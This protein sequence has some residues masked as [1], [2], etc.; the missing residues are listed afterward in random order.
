MF[1]QLLVWLMRAFLDQAAH[2]FDLQGQMM[3]HTRTN[4]MPNLAFWQVSLRHLDASKTLLQAFSPILSEIK[5]L[6]MTRKWCIWHFTLLRFTQAIHYSLPFTFIFC[7]QR[8]YYARPLISFFF[9]PCLFF[10][11]FG[12]FV[13]FLNSYT[14]WA[15]LP[16]NSPFHRGVAKSH[17]WASP[18]RRHGNEG[19]ALLEALVR[20]LS[21]QALHSTRKS[22]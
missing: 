16:A 22:D 20:F 18:D 15:S 2:V 8:F 5:V 9:W 6:F 21:P 11:S 19:R 17:A 1:S 13:S 12:S 7:S 3:S 4:S 10:S 14:C